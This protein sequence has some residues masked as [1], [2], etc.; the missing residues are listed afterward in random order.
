MYGSNTFNY[1]KQIIAKKPG[2]PLQYLKIDQLPKKRNGGNNDS[3]NF[4]Q[5]KS[6]QISRIPLAKLK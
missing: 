6:S 5:P 2:G 3:K 1:S 4:E